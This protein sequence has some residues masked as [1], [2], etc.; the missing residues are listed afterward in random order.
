MQTLP[1]RA[2]LRR[3]DDSELRALSS[4]FSQKGRLTGLGW[5]IGRCVGNLKTLARLA[6][7]VQANFKTNQAD[8]AA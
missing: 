5:D 3:W 1:A 6:C 7:F 2:V 4:R 8:L